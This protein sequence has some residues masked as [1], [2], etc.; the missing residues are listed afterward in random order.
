MRR[1]EPPPDTERLHF[2]EYTLDDLETVA[3]HFADRDTMRYMGGVRG[4]VGSL[5]WLERFVAHYET[6]RHCV[7]ALE[8]KET[9][10]FAGHCGI[11]R[12]EVEGAPE[13]EISYMITRPNWG[14]GLATEAARAARDH[15]I[16]QFGYTR[17]VSLIDPGNEASIRVAEKNGMAL[18][19]TVSWRD[20]TTCVYALQMP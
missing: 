8:L 7:W 6:Y 16:A 13:N 3:P 17:L 1:S 18:E 5:E 12:Q 10:E 11:L 2:R 4:R 20:R 9:G 19:K 15:A 14:R